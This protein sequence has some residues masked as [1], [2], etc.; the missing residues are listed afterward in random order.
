MRRARWFAILGGLVVAVIGIPL[1]GVAVVHALQ[2]RRAARASTVASPL[3]EARSTDNGHNGLVTVHYPSDFR[4]SSL[5]DS[6]IYVERDLGFR[7]YEAVVVAAIVKPPTLEPKAFAHLIF[8]EFAKELTA[9]GAGYV[10]THERPAKCL[11]EYAG[12]EI[13]ATFTRR[14]IPPFVSTSCFWLAGGHGYMVRHDVPKSRAATETP[15][16]ERIET[17]TELR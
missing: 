9:K 5:D 10:K 16:L 12:V 7:E 3:T 8:D 14:I 15:I 6:T 17:A 13:E 1:C 2:A 4:A 11:N